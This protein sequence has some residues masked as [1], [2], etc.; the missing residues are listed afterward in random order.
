MIYINEWN[1]FVLY[2]YPLEVHVFSC[3]LSAIVF[4]SVDNSCA[5]PS[6]NVSLPPIWNAK[7][8]KRILTFYS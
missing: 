7:L 1:I 4:L 8:V 5:H 2:I 6:R 3:F